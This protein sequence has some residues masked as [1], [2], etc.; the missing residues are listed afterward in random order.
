MSSRSSDARRHAR[1]VTRAAR[2]VAV[3]VASALVVVAAGCR[4]TPRSRPD[5]TMA[6]APSAAIDV[7]ARLAD[8]AGTEAGLAVDT[9]L[10]ASTRSLRVC[11]D[12]NNL[13][14]SNRAGAGFENHIAQLIAADL[15]EPLTY[16]WWAQRR[17]FVRNTLA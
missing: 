16:T 9:T 2:C 10:T 6:S 12:P 4:A 7:R 5:T 11:A 1:N 15:H 14:F 13:P 8:A 3:V 17:A